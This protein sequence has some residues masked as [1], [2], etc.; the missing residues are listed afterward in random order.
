MSPSPLQL[1]AGAALLGLGGL[2]GSA[3]APQGPSEAAR[4]AHA[5]PVEVRTVVVRRTIR[6]VRR[7]HPRHRPPVAA[8][9][10]PV[11]P[12]ASSPVVRAA[13]PTP[14]PARV[15]P[16]PPA[17]APPRLRTRASATGHGERGDDHEAGH[18]HGD[19]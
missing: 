11:A 2:A 19:D 6:V 15:R 18:G 9:P 12:P 13:V 17:G 3:L 5:A 8:A 1:T 4:T 7:E 10:T 14:A 16:A